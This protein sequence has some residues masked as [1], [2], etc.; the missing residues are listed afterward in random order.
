MLKY[1][2]SKADKCFNKFAKAFYPSGACSFFVSDE[3]GIGTGRVVPRRVHGGL[4]RSV[5]GAHSLPGE[6]DAQRTTRSDFDAFDQVRPARVRKR[7]GSPVLPLDASHLSRKGDVDRNRLWRAWAV[8][9]G[10]HSRR[11]SAQDQ[12][13]QRT[14]SPHLLHLREEQPRFESKTYIFF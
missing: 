14:D 12:R 4:F 5:Y 10:Q 6:G 7:H 9:L 1:N 2:R 11:H 3:R 8:D 13:H